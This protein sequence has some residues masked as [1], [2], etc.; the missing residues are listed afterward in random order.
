MSFVW[1]GRLTFQLLM[2]SPNLLKCKIPDVQRGMGWGRLTFH[3][4]ML[5]PI[6]CGTITIQ[7]LVWAHA[8]KDGK[9]PAKMV[10]IGNFTELHWNTQHTLLKSYHRCR[11]V[12]RRPQHAQSN[13][14]YRRNLHCFWKRTQCWFSP[15][16]LFGATQIRKW[17]CKLPLC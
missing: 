3:L 15:Q 12:R 11:A 13:N 2:P 8:F 1:W 9:G 17:R 7:C 6:F 4:L 14:I 5:S 16:G 10:C